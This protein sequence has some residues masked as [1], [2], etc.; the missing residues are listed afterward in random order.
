VRHADDVAR[1]ITL[2]LLADCV[3]VVSVTALLAPADSYRLTVT[4]KESNLYRVDGTKFFVKTK[5]CYEYAYSE[6]A[7]LTYEK[8]SYD[9]SL[10]F[11]SSK[12]SCDV[13]KLLSED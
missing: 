4:R 5:Y 13:D 6:A 8:Y 3:D 2:Y 12:T 11:I 7:L 9:N 10:F 1:G